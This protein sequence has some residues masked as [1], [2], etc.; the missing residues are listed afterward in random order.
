MPPWVGRWQIDRR[1]RCPPT[2]PTQRSRP[3]R[4]LPSRS[5]HGRPRPRRGGFDQCQVIRASLACQ[6]LNSR[7]RRPNRDACF[8]AWQSAVR[9]ALA[10]RSGRYCEA[11]SLAFGR[12][13]IRYCDV[14]AVAPGRPRVAPRGDEHRQPGF[15]P[16]DHLRHGRPRLSRRRRRA[17]GGDRRPAPE[18]GWECR[19]RRRPVSGGVRRDG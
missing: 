8:Q 9:G 12:K 13:N 6:S 3:K 15:D 11:L 17:R 14:V 2:P 4:K 19:P 5:W 1:K 10:S 18:P 7:P 16:A